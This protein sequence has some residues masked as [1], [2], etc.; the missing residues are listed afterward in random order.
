[1][2]PEPQRASATGPAPALPDAGERPTVD[3]DAPQEAGTVT[4][5]AEAPAAHP[6]DVAPLPGYEVLG[7][8]GR[9]GMGVVYLARQTKLGR[10]VALKMIRAGQLASAEEVQ[11]FHQ[12]A[13]AAARLDHPGIV[14]IFEVGEHGG[15]HYFSMG[16]V[17][18]GSVAARA[19]DAPLAP[20]AAAELVREVAQA[21]AYA[22]AR[23][24]IHRD[25]K[26]AN[27]LLDAA[28]RPRVSDFGLAKQVQ[29]DSGMTAT[30]Q[31]LGTPSYMP[32][33]QAAGRHDATA[34]AADL[35]ALGAILYRLL[36]GRP[37]FQA[38]SVMET[39]Q[40]VLEREPVPPRQLNA[41]V[42]RDLETICLK[43][44]QKD[45]A[46]R[47]ASAEALADDLRRFLAG[48]PIR[49]RP[50]RRLERA[51]R[52]CRR[53]PLDAL[54]IGTIVLLLVAGAAVCAY[55]AVDATRAKDK[56]LAEKQRADDEAD[57]AWNNQYAAHMNLTASDWERPN[58]G[59][60]R[61][62]LALYREPPAGRKDVRGWEWYF[63]D[64]RCAQELRTL[65]GHTHEVC[66]AAFSPDGTLLASASD[67]QTVRIWDTATGQVLHTLPHPA[68][69]NYATFSPD[70]ALLVSCSE[71]ETVRLWD[72]R[73]AA[74]LHSFKGHTGDTWCAAFSPDG[75]RL[76]SGSVDRTVKLWDVATGEELRT[77]KGHTNTVR[78]V[79]FTPDGSR[80][81]S[82]SQ[83]A[84]VK[85]WDANTGAVLRTLGGHGGGGV[86]VSP[87][88][89]WFA[90]TAGRKIRLWELAT[91]KE[92][93][94]L[95]GHVQNVRG[96]AFS[97]DGTRLVS[98]SHDQTMRL[99]D[100]A[101][102]KELRTFKGHTAFVWNATFNPAGTRIA[103]A[104][105]D[106]TVKLWDAGPGRLHGTLVGHGGPVVS[107]AF[108]PDGVRLASASGDGT[109]TL[110]DAGT[111]QELRT[112]RWPAVPG[113]GGA[114][115]PDGK[116]LAA[117]GVAFRRDGRRLAAGGGDG[118]VKVWDPAGGGEVLGWQAHDRAVLDVAFS[119]DGARIA[120]GG[121][122]AIVKLWDAATGR[123]LHTLTG[124]TRAAR[125]VAFSPDGR[126]LA[127]AGGRD[128][129]KLWDVA[130]GA[131]RA[132][133]TNY[134]L[135]NAALAFSP[136]GARL[137]LAS[138]LGPITLWDSHTGELL[139]TLKGHVA[140]VEGLTFSPDG[141]RLASA[142]G[143]GVAK[144]WDA[145]AGTELYSFKA[146]GSL[147]CIAFSPDGRWLV[148]GS[149]GK[150]AH[151]W[152][153]R[154]ASPQLHTEAEAL[155]LLEVLLDR[156]LP[157]AD[158]RAAIESE[159]ILSDAA[160]RQALEILDR[161]PE[162]TDP[163]KYLDAA[164]PILQHPYANV[165]QCR[166][167][168]I[169]AQAACTRAPDDGAYRLALA[170][171]QYRLGR[172]QKEQYAHARTTLAGC[173]PGNPTTL[174]F[175]A[176]THY[177][178]GEP[179]QARA[180]LARLRKM[181]KAA[182]APFTREAVALIEAAS[183]RPTRP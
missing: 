87:D 23:G 90:A 181:P 26:P 101:S 63:Q 51:W 131:Q 91:V 97:P 149:G 100:L 134:S 28:G 119:P 79:A 172:Y 168:L 123:L 74:A 137:A 22:H 138:S 70:G 139:R 164:W 163:K 89:K 10:L 49:A 40:Q 76:A 5:A 140:S 112:F 45:P 65:T 8:L 31:V 150:H 62:T 99:W 133:L 64:G 158:V 33:E 68:R 132:A 96:V 155:G 95:E 169:Q 30:G 174:A 127:S 160:R 80:L 146:A 105:A 29:R 143:D 173:A 21:V 142:A 85:V 12:E 129:A 39:L 151:L 159:R 121:A 46:R 48:E 161:F 52:W 84:T 147:R 86:T 93:R 56:A 37:P 113:V 44:L 60:V 55:L 41:A 42:P 122:D 59:R 165:D 111:R 141:T 3:L 156:P 6:V 19:K 50:V 58:L 98:T 125:A 152:D 2:T 66:S 114:P 102:G 73:T 82:H 7:P 35:Y 38:A 177:Q 162:E 183:A 109:V 18:G 124:H 148:T 67:D 24:V 120:S 118:T 72:V 104:G 16:Y 106:G 115:G 4:A 57:T 17:E 9:G 116:R 11:R 1:M 20:R 81:V 166:L 154:P 32:P 14:P 25:L 103:S 176:M 27:I 170:I 34:P 75:K 53:N 36:T 47:Y 171:A 43:C 78:S 144:L 83:D 13:E 157:R 107:I 88:G 126:L 77:F 175:V 54:L 182:A 94:A 71:D 153:A 135:G 61:E 178:L 136:D 180:A 167:A 15:H 117:G 179:D 128:E 108:S 69:L 92:L 145:A 110:W 130:T